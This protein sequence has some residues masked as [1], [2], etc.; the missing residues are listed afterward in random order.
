M[1]KNKIFLIIL[2]FI[3]II[4]DIHPDNNKV[5][6]PDIY[7]I[8][9]FN[10]KK[11]YYLN[12]A[13]IICSAD[14]EVNIK[15]NNIKLLRG[16]IW[17][18]S[19]KSKLLKII[20]NKN[21]FEITGASV[22]INTFTK[23]VSV[24]NGIIYI[25]GKRVSKGQTINLNKMQIINIKDKDNWQN[26]N[27]KAE[28]TSVFL[29]I[30]GKKEIKDTFSNYIIKKVKDNYF[31]SSDNE[32]E[33]LVKINIPESEGV[34][35]G[36]ITHILSQQIIGII[37]E[38]IDNKSS[39]EIAALDTGTRICEIINSFIENELY[40]GRIIIIETTD[41]K[42]E[43]INDFKKLLSVITTGKILEEKEYYKIKNVLKYSYIGDGYD[44]AEIIKKSD[45]KFNIYH[46]SKNNLKIKVQN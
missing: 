13:K 25:S 33:F 43:D 6:N 31:T 5:K 26:E 12:G 29:E 3:F 36:T 11:V 38:K 32:Q 16:R 22:D 40:K 37:D 17:V 28:I 24:F 1:M 19:A 14:S 21:I 18:T 9:Y 4:A 23:L 35:K 7:K 8:D 44:I 10:G 45:K 15:D 27:I 2:I 46:I 20:F 30:N 34:I 39:Y 41:F 42:T